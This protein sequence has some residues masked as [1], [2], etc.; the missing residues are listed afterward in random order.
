MVTTINHD[1]LGLKTVFGLMAGTY[2]I[3]KYAFVLKIHFCLI[4]VYIVIT[5]WYKLLA[6]R[7]IKFQ[8]DAVCVWLQNDGTHEPLLVK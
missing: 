2:G 7:H 5:R 1:I 8:E 3:H 6:V 4:P